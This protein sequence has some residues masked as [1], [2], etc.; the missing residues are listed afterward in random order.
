MEEIEEAKEKGVKGFNNQVIAQSQ[1]GRYKDESQ[2][3]YDF[4]LNLRPV[5]CKQPS[6]ALD[7]QRIN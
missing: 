1:T 6:L 3:C 4:K 5:E 2:D 7:L